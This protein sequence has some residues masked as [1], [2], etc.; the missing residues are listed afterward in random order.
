MSEGINSTKL[1]SLRLAGH[2]SGIQLLF[3]GPRMLNINQWDQT[4]PD[5]GFKWLYALFESN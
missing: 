3:L 1:S 5:L 2:R 4:L